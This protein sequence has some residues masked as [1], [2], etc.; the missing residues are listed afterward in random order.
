VRLRGGVRREGREAR[1]IIL[2][3]L[4]D[5]EEKQINENREQ[6]CK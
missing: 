5:R 3:I 1:K 2:S 4:E 6:M